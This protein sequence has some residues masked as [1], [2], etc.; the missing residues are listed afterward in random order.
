MTSRVQPDSESTDIETVCE[1]WEKCLN[2]K[3]VLPTD[4]VFER[5]A[6]SLTSTSF[7][8][9]LEK[10]TKKK[11]PFSELFN[12]PTPELFCRRLPV[13]EEQGLAPVFYTLRQADRGSPL[14][15]IPPSQRGVF[16]Y[17]YF[18]DYLPK[19]IPIY[20]VE[21]RISAN[22]AHAY[23]SLLTM[24]WHVT[25]TIVE[26]IP[27]GKILLC[28]YSFG[29]TVAWEVA[30]QLTARGR[31]VDMLFLLDPSAEPLESESVIIR[32]KGVLTK[33]LSK[34]RQSKKQISSFSH[35]GLKMH[36]PT[37]VLHPFRLTRRIVKKLITERNFDLPVY[38]KV[39]FAF[40]KGYDYGFYSGNVILYRINVQFSLRRILS[41][42]I[43][44]HGRI[45]GKLTIEPI[46]GDHEEIVQKKNAA[47]ISRHMTKTFQEME[48]ESADQGLPKTSLER[49]PWQEP[50]TDS[51]ITQRFAEVVGRVGDK[52]CVD[53]N[54]KV[55]TY[56]ELDRFSDHLA[57]SLGDSSSSSDKPVAIILSNGWRYL[58]TILGC[59]KAGRT[60]IP[61]DSLVPPNRVKTI[62]EITKT[63]EIITDDEGVNLVKKLKLNERLQI[64]HFD[65]LDLKS[66]QAKPLKKLSGKTKAVLLFTSGSTG[67]PKG[68]LHTHRSIIH[69]AWRRSEAYGL[70]PAD[71]YSMLYSGLFMGCVSG[72]YTALMSGASLHYYPIKE[73]GVESLEKWLSE[74]RIT[75]LHTITTILRRFF[76]M[77]KG[78]ADLPSLRIV[79]PGGEASRASD[80]EM[81]KALFPTG[82]KYT[83]HISS[84][85]CG[86][87]AFNPIDHDTIL[88]PGPI[89]V[90]VPYPSLNVQIQDENGTEL[91]QGEEGEIV[92]NSPFILSGYWNTM[93]DADSTEDYPLFRTGDFGMINSEGQLVNLGRK[94]GLI[95]INGVRIEIQEVES[96]L[97]QLDD[98][99]EGVV[100]LR[101]D[102]TEAASSQL[103]AF[104]KPAHKSNKKRIRNQLALTLPPSMIP[105]QFISLEALPVTANEKI[106]RRKLTYTPIAEL[107]RFEWSKNG[108]D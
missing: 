59:L 15:F 100:V 92:V 75:V 86:P 57:N 93:K 99:E 89:P 24:A 85:E 64:Q 76:R 38:A 62:L 19:D 42:A 12:N 90:G 82:C 63:A 68:V 5:G 108:S 39:Q 97:N 106:D 31:T 88:P 77:L 102:L 26:N 17:K 23:P 35:Y 30:K 67:V 44:W 49:I 22:G 29:G 58:V 11:I 9:A 98:V 34:I 66:V 60:Y 18:L 21:P 36:L 37:F 104:Y 78:P 6:D 33:Y 96:A 7:L 50:T 73:R 61:L 4:N 27:E 87:L 45:T 70:T 80:I 83:A 69:M 14:V 20:L 13:F 51:S 28:G 2:L 101:K 48:K 72:V 55:L 56:Y 105:A 47:R 65:D 25:N 46:S 95:K 107:E 3:T 1:L 71:R 84:T 91:K 32:D 43:G 79:N 8:V 81:F 52:I 41:P 40:K 74:N 16:H 103:V 94:D 53:D 10:K 54:V